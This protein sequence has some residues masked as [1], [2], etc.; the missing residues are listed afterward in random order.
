[1]PSD[2]KRKEREREKGKG[3]IGKE[4]KSGGIHVWRGIRRASRNGG[5][6]GGFGGECKMETCLETLLELGFCTKPPNIKVEAH[7]EAL[8]GIALSDYV[9]Y[10][11]GQ[12]AGCRRFRKKIV[13]HGI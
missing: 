12:Y 1:M 9:Q 5:L 2:A 8:A 11:C 13:V 7:M 3:K 6:E 4:K 10:Q